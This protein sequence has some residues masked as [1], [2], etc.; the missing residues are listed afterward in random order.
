MVSAVS[1]G[2]AV[3]GCGYWGINYLR[4]LS[5]LG[6]T[7]V[8]CTDLSPDRLKTVAQQYPRIAIEPDLAHIL[9]RDDIRAVILATTAST[10]FGLARAVIERGK[11]VLVEK[12]LTLRPED[13]RQLVRLARDKG[14]VLMVA[15]TFLYNPAIRRMKQLLERGEAGSLYYLHARRTHLG[16]VRDDVSALWDLAPHDV[17]IFGYLLDARP[18]IVTASGGRYLGRDQV[19]AVFATLAY[20][21]DVLANLFVSWV[22]SNKVR[23]VAVVGSRARLVFDDLNNLE[24]LRIFEKGISI[25]RQ[26]R[27]F[28]EFQL[29]LRDG[30]IVSPRLD[31]GEPLRILTEEFLACVSERREP[32]SPGVSGW[33]VVTILDAIER[34]VR[35]GGDPV[36]IDWSAAP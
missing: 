30:D 4:I 33:E 36:K 35:A 16:L 13:A 12:P 28:G 10:H 26:Y 15:H 7:P 6:S 27:D 25:D 5:L 2:I 3:V 24:K 17:S 18:E 34:S 9:D 22:D 21:G 19:D 32:M 14:A 29:L 8:V 11:D 20:R 23:E 31:V 1:S